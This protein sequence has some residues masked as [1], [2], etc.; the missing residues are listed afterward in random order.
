MRGD[1]GTYTV[2]VTAGEA[3][4]TCPAY[5]DCSHQA[6]A[7]SVAMAGA[8]PPDQP[9]QA[10]GPL[11]RLYTWSFRDALAAQLEGVVLVRI[12]LGK[13]RWASRG[14]ANA[15]PYIE[16]LAPRGMFHVDDPS[17]F[18][19]L[20]R[21]RLD[22]FGPELLVR[23]FRELADAH[24]GLPLLPLV[25]LCFERDRRDCHRGDFAEW[26]QERTGQAVPEFT[27]PPVAPV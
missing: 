4:C 17:E 12:S 20:Y 23:R 18:R 13:P 22:G 1:H 2:T 26:W 5:G 11:P 10:A 15:M 27:D 14:V 6:A 9:D 21:E 16:E 19:R 24:D 8:A 3:A 25:L 7:L